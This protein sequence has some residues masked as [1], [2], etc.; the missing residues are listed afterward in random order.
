MAK[1]TIKERI[2]SARAEMN[3]TQ[4]AFGARLG[5]AKRTVQD[6]ES[7]IRIPGKPVMMLLDI[8]KKPA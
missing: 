8:I 1:K 4:E 7:G 5:V 2:R 6:W 3:L